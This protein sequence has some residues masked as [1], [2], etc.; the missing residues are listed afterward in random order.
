MK[1]LSDAKRR[2]LDRLKRLGPVTAGRL[3]ME[4]GLTDMAVRQ[5]L[6]VLQSL[7]LVRAEKQPPKGR[8]R[9]SVHWSLT[10]VAMKLF[11]DRH[12]GLTLD[13]LKAAH[14]AFGEAGIESLLAVRTRDQISAYREQLPTNEAPLRERVTALARQRTAE[15]YMAEAI[16]EASGSWLLVEHHCPICTAA[17]GCEGLCRSELEVFRQSLGDDI[18]IERTQHLLTNSDRC[19]YRI[20]PTSTQD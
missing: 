18:T 8:G 16:E 6:Q 1:T 13:L 9:P 15:G 3:A 19:V 20:E 4:L 17:Q 10:P 5:H 2:L 11:P 7:Q 12:A 14:E